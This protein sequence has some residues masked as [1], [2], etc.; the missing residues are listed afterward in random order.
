MV[1]AE[2]PVEKDRRNR[3]HSGASLSL[4]SCQIMIT[5]EHVPRGAPTITSRMMEGIY[6]P[7]ASL[8]QGPCG[9]GFLCLAERGLGPA[10]A[11]AATSMTSIAVEEGPPAA[12]LLVAVLE[13]TLLPGLNMIGKM[14]L[15]TK[16][17][18]GRNERVSQAVAETVKSL[19]LKE[20][21]AV[22]RRPIIGSL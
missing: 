3:H 19:K 20:A 21:V 11:G 12:V 18:K 7:P 17:N 15:K 4:S 2:S 10:A 16:R 1:M 22:R 14:E 6:C 13:A 5:Q 8:G 9:L